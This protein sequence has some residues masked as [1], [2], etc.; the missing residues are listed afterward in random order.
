MHSSL[1]NFSFPKFYHLSLCSHAVHFFFI[2]HQSTNGIIR[3]VQCRFIASS[4]AQWIIF[5]LS[6]AFTEF[7]IFF[8]SHDWLFSEQEKKIFAKINEKYLR[9]YTCNF[10]VDF[11]FSV[12]R[13]VENNPYAFPCDVWDFNLPKGYWIDIFSLMELFPFSLLHFPRLIL[14]LTAKIAEEI[15]ARVNEAKVSPSRCP[16]SFVIFSLGFFARK[17][18]AARNYHPLHREN[19]MSSY[20]I[21]LYECGVCNPGEKL[22]K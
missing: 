15:W 5:P 2:L 14:K 8:L 11:C 17:N 16:L 3:Y 20:T 4:K 18:L 19:R 22:A 7:L 1:Q 10:G 9:F 12:R 6:W 21:E 13:K